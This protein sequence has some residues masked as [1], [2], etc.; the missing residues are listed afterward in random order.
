MLIIFIYFCLGILYLKFY[1]ISY[2]NGGNWSGATQAEW[3]SENPQEEIQCKRF[4]FLRGVDWI[5]YLFVGTT[6]L[7]VKIVCLFIILLITNLL[8]RHRPHNLP[9]L[10]VRCYICL[11]FG[12]FQ[13]KII[14]RIQGLMT[15]NWKKIYSWKK[16]HF[17]IKNCNLLI[18]RPPALQN[19]N[20][21]PVGRFWPSWIR[22]VFGIANAVPYTA[23]QNELFWIKNYNLPIPRPP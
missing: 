20:F 7:S 3:S 16:L 2:T 8:Q 10:L 1:R 18:P 23:E 12:I 13:V 11:N 14:S 15:K 17:L 9:A 22:N 21:L 4:N 5:P 6:D 19:L